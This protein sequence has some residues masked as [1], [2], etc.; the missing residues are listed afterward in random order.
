MA[1]SSLKAE[2]ANQSN[3]HCRD[4]LGGEDTVQHSCLTSSSQTAARDFLSQHRLWF[5]HGH[6]S[7]ILRTRAQS[8]FQV[9]GLCSEGLL[10]SATA[11]KRVSGMLFC[12]IPRHRSCLLKMSPASDYGSL[13]SSGPV[14]KLI[15]YF[16]EKTQTHLH[17]KQG[18][19]GRRLPPILVELAGVQ[20]EIQA[21]RW[22]KHLNPW[23]VFQYVR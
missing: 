13:S 1:Q 9:H 22:Q 12:G 16:T 19:V 11:G 15:F 20:E 14:R 17:A 2:F 8:R 7:S 4:R 18:C 6:L 5:Q 21:Q 23:T 3:H 10:S